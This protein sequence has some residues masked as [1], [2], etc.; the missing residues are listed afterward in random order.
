LRRAKYDK[1]DFV[2]PKISTIISLA[3]PRTLQISTPYVS[4]YDRCTA[5]HHHARQD[6]KKTA[7][8]KLFESAHGDKN[9]SN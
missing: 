2:K 3:A 9:I 4:S 8:K 5:F 1:K 6:C 7:G